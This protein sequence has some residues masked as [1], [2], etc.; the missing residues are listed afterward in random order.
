MKAMYREFRPRIFDD[1]KGQPH[2]TAVLKRQAAEKTPSHAYLF[3]GPRGTGKTSTAKILAMALNCENNQNGNPCLKCENCRQALADANVDIIEIDAASNNSVDSIRELREKVNLL[4]ASGRYKVYIIDEVH[5]LSIS[6][7]NALL[8]TLEEPPAH[9]VFILATTELRKLPATVLSRCQRFDFKRIDN[10]KIAERM[11]EVLSEVGATAEEEAL[12]MIAR[13][14]DGALRDALSLLDKC[15]DIDKNVTAGL[16]HD[17]LGLADS[18]LINKL[19]NAVEDYDAET[20]MYA[21]EEL[22][23]QGTDSM[24]LVTELMQEFR[25]ILV[26]KPN[27]RERELVRA[28]E[29]LADAENKMKFSVR[30]SIILETAIMRILLPETDNN[31]GDDARLRKLEADVERLK[32]EQ[33]R[34]MQAASSANSFPKGNLEEIFAGTGVKITE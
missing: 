8:K 1:V 28:V 33:E 29:T 26:E 5:M 19:I 11:R 23:A 20:A 16:V 15:C 34:V 10:G 6:A 12:E 24:S 25:N 9:V 13:A 3:A 21:V 32:S 22:M 2:I 18:V 14:A 4:P 27:G 31:S 7:F 30:P 17:V